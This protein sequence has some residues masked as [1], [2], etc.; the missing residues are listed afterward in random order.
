MKNVFLVL[1]SL[2]LI[3][4]SNANA[5]TIDSLYNASS[6]LYIYNFQNVFL[7]S[8]STQSCSEFANGTIEIISSN[9]WSLGSGTICE[10]PAGFLSQ[11]MAETDFTLDSLTTMFGFEDT[12]AGKL[13]S[14]MQYYYYVPSLNEHFYVSMYL[15]SLPQ[16]LICVFGRSAVIDKMQVDLVMNNIVDNYQL[17]LGF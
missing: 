12:L 5:Q 11:M 6:Q 17:Q 7:Q 13:S 15:I 3:F 1:I 10:K 2:L 16:N 14:L 4:T 8:D 9:T